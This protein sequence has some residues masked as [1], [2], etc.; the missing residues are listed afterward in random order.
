MFPRVKGLS[1]DHVSVRYKG[2]PV[3]A[4]SG[5]DC[6]VRPGE[7]VALLGDNGAGKSSLVKAIAGLLEPSAGSVRYDGAPVTSA[8]TLRR[9][10]EEIAYMPQSSLALNNL[11]VNQALWYTARLRGLSRA[12]AAQSV[13]SVTQ[14]LDLG[15]LAKRSIPTLSGGQRRRAQLGVTL[16]GSPRYLVLDEPSNDLDPAWRG[17]VWNLLRRVG[18]RGVG[19]L[20]VSHDVAGVESIADRVVILQ[21]GRVSADGTPGQLLH[22]H[23]EHVRITYTLRDGSTVPTV[24]ASALELSCEGEAHTCLVPRED[25]GRVLSDEEFVLAYDVR[26]RSASLEDVYLGFVDSVAGGD[27][28]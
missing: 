3:D 17:R 20:I 13:A 8:A 10:R 21:R 26:V 4:L 16:V 23:G 28:G 27:H 6:E 2:N 12:A 9:M 24:V 22:D 5:V 18:D 15:G 25:L 1:A 11:T 14:W 7:V 19:V